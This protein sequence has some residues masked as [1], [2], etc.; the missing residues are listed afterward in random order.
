MSAKRRVVLG[1]FALLAVLAAG[2][3]GCRTE[4]TLVVGPSAQDVPAY[5]EPLAHCAQMHGYAVP[6]VTWIARKA[7]PLSNGAATCCIAN[8]EPAVLERWGV[9][10][11]Y[12]AVP[13]ET[14]RSFKLKIADRCTGPTGEQF[15]AN[16][17][18][19]HHEFTHI[20]LRAATGDWD[21]GHKRSLWTDCRNPFDSRPVFGPE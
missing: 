16:K 10:G 15:T 4:S 20:I 17:W 18:Y 1:A 2:V 19:A 21:A 8:S 6:P 12:G 5:L 11:C 9:V 7:R 14:A 13:I 3:T